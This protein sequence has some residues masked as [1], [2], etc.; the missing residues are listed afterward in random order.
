MYSKEEAKKMRNEFWD[1]F[2]LYSS[3]RRRRK[4]KPGNWMM[5]ATGIRAV[6]LKFHFDTESALVG[7]DIETGSLDKRIELF[8]RMEGLKKLLDQAMETEMTW[9]L[10]YVRENGK[11]VSRIFTLIRDVSIYERE[12]WPLVMKFF[13]D[14]MSR[15]EEFFIEY[16]DYIR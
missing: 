4:G 2:R 6:N 12:T 1:S 13:F 16:K 9:E 3:S 11:S 5:D 7:L 10:D 14:K 8:E 15:L